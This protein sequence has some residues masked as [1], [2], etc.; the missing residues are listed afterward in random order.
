METS[1]KLRRQTAG[2]VKSVLCNS[3]LFNSFGAMLLTSCLAFAQIPT[4]PLV[5]L[6]NISSAAS[7][8]AGISAGGL[9]TA[10]GS[11]LANQTASASAIPLPTTLGGTQVQITDGSGGTIMAGLLYVSPTQ[12]NFEV[13]DWAVPGNATVAIMSGSASYRVPIPLLKV[14]P[15]LFA[16]NTQEVAA[17]TA[18]QVVLPTQVQSN[19][20]VFRCVDTPGSCRLVPIALG[21][22]TPIYVS[23]YGTGIRGRSSLNNTVVTI[24]GVAVT[25]VYA[26]PQSQF[27]GLDQVVVPLSLSL[28]GAG[29]VNVTLAVDGLQS[30]AVQIDVQ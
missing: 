21:V 16:V 24:G 20:P 8:T 9:A 11:N 17:A 28:R 18:I 23:F 13:P 29:T 4:E 15:S 12:I 7:G 27:A 1:A 30:N 2:V 25:P 6:I 26:G 3:L 14:A 10:T 22:D 19:V 5:P